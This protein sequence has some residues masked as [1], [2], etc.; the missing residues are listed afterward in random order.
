[1]CN[2]NWSI[3][4]PHAQSTSLERETESGS[5]KTQHADVNSSS[6]R[7]WFSF[8][9]SSNDQNDQTDQIDPGNLTTEFQEFIAKCIPN[10]IR[11]KDNCPEFKLIFSLF[12]W[13]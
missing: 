8:N 5:E 10:L 6:C 1:M 7:S 3:F 11:R 12:I 13:R 2:S 9:F 4:V